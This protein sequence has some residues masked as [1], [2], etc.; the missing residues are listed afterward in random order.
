MF[1]LMLIM[2][3]LTG[4]S[5]IASEAAAVRAERFDDSCSL[6]ERSGNKVIVFE[7]TTDKLIGLRYREK[8]VIIVVFPGKTIMM[9]RHFFSCVFSDDACDGIEQC[10]YIETAAGDR[11]IVAAEQGTLRAFDPAIDC[12]R[13]EFWNE[14]DDFICVQ[15]GTKCD[16]EIMASPVVVCAAGVHVAIPDTTLDGLFSIIYFAI[17]AVTGVRSEWFESPHVGEAA[18]FWSLSP[19]RCAEYESQSWP[20]MRYTANIKKPDGFVLSHDLHRFNTSRVGAK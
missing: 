9:Q 3:L 15:N 4:S 6:W 16:D 2:A 10:N 17:S 18:S 1:F 12:A 20:I 13:Q 11:W 7:N 8:E 14:T 5:C 19:K